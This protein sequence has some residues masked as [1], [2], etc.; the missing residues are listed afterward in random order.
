MIKYFFTFVFSLIV[1]FS[2][3]T[4][5]HAAVKAFPTA[6]GLGENTVGGR[7]GRVMEV[8]N[9]DDAGTGSLR[10]CME[11]TGRRICVFRVAGTI[12]LNSPIK[13]HEENSYLTI[14]GQTAP[15]DGVQIKNWYIS[16]SYGVHD[17]IV[18]YLRLR[19]G[20]DFPIT[21]GNNDC[22][23][24]FIYAPG[25]THT[26]NIILDHTSLAWSCDDTLN[27]DA[28]VTDTTIQWSLIGPGDGSASKGL[29]TTENNL[30]FPS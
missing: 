30:E 4:P 20:R 5:T 22:G 17:V 15:G 7:G 19:T 23:G 26:Y 3:T 11:S 28:F 2:L 27:V 9:L 14:A 13:V 6:E 12:A 18:R 10:A 8:T 25:G 29:I 24:I 1:F 21:D 16:L